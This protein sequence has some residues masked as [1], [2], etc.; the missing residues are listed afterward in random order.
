[1]VSKIN[2]I[3]LLLSPLGEGAETGPS[4]RTRMLNLEIEKRTPLSPLRLASLYFITLDLSLILFGRRL[5]CELVG[6]FIMYI[7]SVTFEPN[8]FDAS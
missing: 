6:P 8:D 1:M 3:N 4:P 7:P 5:T 2:G